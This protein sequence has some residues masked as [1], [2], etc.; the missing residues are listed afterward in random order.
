MA[1]RAPLTTSTSHAHP[2]MHA[3]PDA[4]LAKVMYVSLAVDLSQRRATASPQRIARDTR[5]SSLRG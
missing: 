3:A 1:T 2:S 5:E 4:L